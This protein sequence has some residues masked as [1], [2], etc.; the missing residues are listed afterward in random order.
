MHRSDLPVLRIALVG[1]GH[2][3]R[4][5]YGPA[6]SNMKDEV[7]VRAVCDLQHTTAADMQ[8]RYFRGA[9]I[10]TDVSRLLEQEELDAVLVLTT[11]TANADIAQR[12]LLA[13]I[14]VYLE[15]PPA[16]SLKSLERLLA[17]E[18]ESSAFVYTAF[19]RRHIPLFRILTS[20][21]TAKFEQVTGVL[22]RTD[23]SVDAFPFT[24]VHLIDSAQYF[25]GSTFA[26]YEV[27]FS[28]NGTARWSIQGELRNG[29]TC[30][31]T[32]VPDG[33]HEEETII[34]R[35]PEKRCE[36]RFPD[37]DGMA[38]RV[39]M[40]LQQTGDSEDRDLLDQNR[41]SLEIMGYVPCLQEFL[42][43]V[44]DKDLAASRHRLHFCTETIRILEAMQT[45]VSSAVTQ[46]FAQSGALTGRF[47]DVNV[48]TRNSI[49]DH[50]PFAQHS[51]LQKD[52]FL[53]EKP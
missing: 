45:S 23:R 31:L 29:A 17:A 6:L 30:N 19:N 11:E 28:R 40:I 8:Q 3:T 33:N 44:R 24:S 14:P 9:R 4:T 5:V 27:T 34:L 39:R 41:D 32:F 7:Q 22:Q 48:E 10:Y 12:A 15:K 2:I 50:S 51:G 26:S 36:L 46:Q 42:R 53:P 47:E 16:V 38:P 49:D 37:C 18:A 35:S 21:D 13:E 25:C 52:L 20:S 1:C 43:H